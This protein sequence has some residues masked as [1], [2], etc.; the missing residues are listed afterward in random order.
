MML[1]Q[2]PIEYDDWM[3]LIPSQRLPT[4]EHF[5]YI[6][7][8]PGYDQQF[9]M[10]HSARF[11]AALNKS[12]G[13]MAGVEFAGVQPEVYWKESIFLRKQIVSAVKWY[14]G[15]IVHMWC[16]HTHIVWHCSDADPFSEEV[17]ELRASIFGA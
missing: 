17:E 13:V 4:G 6:P 8:S 2:S 16:L 1:N 14:E 12:P 7:V 15:C 5:T 10:H 9:I 3:D 11:G